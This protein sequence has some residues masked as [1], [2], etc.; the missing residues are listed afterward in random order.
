MAMYTEGISSSTHA[1]NTAQRYLRSLL[2]MRIMNCWM[3]TPHF[4]PGVS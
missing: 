2:L 3:G 1:A 4:L